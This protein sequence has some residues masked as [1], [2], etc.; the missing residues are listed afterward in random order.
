MPKKPRILFVDD[1]PNVLDAIRRELRSRSADWDMAFFS[2]PVEALE[3]HK[4]SSFDV[5]VTDL[6]MPKMDGFD[7]IRGILE[8]SPETVIIMLTGAADLSVT[9]KA[10]NENTVFRFYSK[11]CAA[12]E[13]ARGIEAALRHKQKNAS[14]TPKSVTEDDVVSRVSPF[15]TGVDPLLDHLRIGAVI[16]DKDGRIVFTNQTGADLIVKNDGLVITG[17]GICRAT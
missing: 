6:K 12:T 16:V 14:P 8:V 17:T 10:I 3:C 11:P 5:A 7:A 2:S 4:T 1:E 13:L 15:P 9:V